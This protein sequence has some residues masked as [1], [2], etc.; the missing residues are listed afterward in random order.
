MDRLT[1]PPLL[2]FPCLEQPSI[3]WTDVSQF[4]M[5]A[6]STQVQNYLNRLKSTLQLLD[7]HAV[8]HQQ[9]SGIVTFTG[10]FRRCCYDGNST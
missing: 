6:L 7:Q 9:T 10:P 4:K 8:T 1:L 3:F 2:L 5:A